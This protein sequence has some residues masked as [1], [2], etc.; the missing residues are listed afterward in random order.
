MKKMTSKMK[1]Y[2]KTT[3]LLLACE[4]GVP[5]PFKSSPTFSQTISTGGLLLTRSQLMI[6]PFAV[7]SGGTTCLWTCMK[8]SLTSAQSVEF[9]TMR[10]I[11]E[12]CSAMHAALEL[13]Q[14]YFDSFWIDIQIIFAS[15]RATKTSPTLFTP[16]SMVLTKYLW[17]LWSFWSTLSQRILRIHK[18]TVK[19]TRRSTL[20]V[21]A[22]MAHLAMS[23][24]S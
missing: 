12:H 20:R 9:I 13:Q 3:L 22:A 4:H 8:L 7:L 17:R 6:H 21:T 10:A 11:E 1:K 18:S 2:Q 5:W 19:R 16:A 15:R 23:L 24:N 14:T